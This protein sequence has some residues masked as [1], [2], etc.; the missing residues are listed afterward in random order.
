MT[1]TIQKWGNSLAVRLP[2]AIATEARI[3]EGVQIELV[4]TKEGIL[5]KPARRRAYRVSQLVAAITPQNLHAE[6]CWGPSVGA[7]IVR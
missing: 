2:K 1:A 3:T 6:T 7:E 4:K 5:L